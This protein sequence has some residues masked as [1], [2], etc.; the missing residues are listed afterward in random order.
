MRR[1]RRSQSSGSVEMQMGP[2]IDMVFL[3]LVF[4]MVSAKPVKQEADIGIG[5]PG[6]LAQETPVDIPEEI[7]VEINASGGVV[8]NEQPLALPA[9]RDMLR[10]FKESADANRGEALVSVAPHDA[11]PH[12]KLVDVL[13]ACAAAGVTGVTFVDQTSGEGEP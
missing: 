7:T 11:V 6:A 10:R 13:D 4:F 12:Q 8:V 1:R 2:M 3:L 5:L 9:L